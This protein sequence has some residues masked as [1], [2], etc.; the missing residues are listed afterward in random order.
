MSVPGATTMVSYI[1]SGQFSSTE[2]AKIGGQEAG[3]FH[4]RRGTLV[5][6][7]EYVSMIT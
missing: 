3:A 7:S 5:Q 4:R 1:A 2:K 6:S